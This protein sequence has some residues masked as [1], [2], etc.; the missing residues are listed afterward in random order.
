MLAWYKR[1][2]AKRTF[3]AMMQFH[4]LNSHNFDATQ[5]AY[6]VLSISQVRTVMY[7]WLD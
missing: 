3:R 5:N 4:K 1:W 2:Q 6:F 7:G